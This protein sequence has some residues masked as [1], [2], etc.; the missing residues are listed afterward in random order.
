MIG[1]VLKIPDNGFSNYTTYKVV[2]GDTLYSI[3]LRYNTTIDAIKT[4]NNLQSNILSI[5]QILKIPN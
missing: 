3:A 1:Q 2:S 4:L 5:G